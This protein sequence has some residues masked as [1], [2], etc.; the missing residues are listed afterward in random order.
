MV[1]WQA[2]RSGAAVVKGRMIGSDGLP[3][4]AVFTIGAGA[5]PAA[6]AAIDGSYTVLTETGTVGSRRIALYS[7]DKTGALVSKSF[8]DTKSKGDKFN[9]AIGPTRTGVCWHGSRRAPTVTAT[10][11]ASSRA[12]STRRPRRRPSSSTP[13]PRATR[14]I[15]R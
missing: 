4:G 11:A 14:A 7:Y 3:A 5:N 15:R 2:Q 6:S 1:V 10:A 12:S 8:A 13:P 9:P